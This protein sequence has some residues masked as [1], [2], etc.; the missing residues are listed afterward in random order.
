MPAIH[1]TKKVL[2]R[3][4]KDKKIPKDW[5]LTSS[6]KKGGIRF[7]KDGTNNGK[8]IRVMRGDPNSRWPTS[9]EPYVR[10][11]KNGRSSDINGKPTTDPNAYHIPLRLFRQFPDWLKNTG[12][13]D[14]M[15]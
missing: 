15:D 14:V 13:T 2:E 9:R 8:Y 1:S 11:Q 5:R 10:I 3:F 6:N 7:I 4:R 12:V